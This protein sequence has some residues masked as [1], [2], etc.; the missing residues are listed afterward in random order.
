MSNTDHQEIRYTPAMAAMFPDAGETKDFTRDGLIAWVAGTSKDIQHLT[1]AVDALTSRIEE[2][3]DRFDRD[4]DELRASQGEVHDV[5]STQLELSRRVISL[6]TEKATMRTEIDDL[7]LWVVKA[8]V[9]GAV[10]GG[11]GGVI[12]SLAYFLVGKIWK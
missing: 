2:L 10:V 9:V 3:A 6:E 5:R 11:I 7:K 1:K 8:K 12:G 4:A